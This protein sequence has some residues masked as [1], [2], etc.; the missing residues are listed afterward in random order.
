MVPGNATARLELTRIYH[1]SAAHRLASPRL[2]PAANARVY[3]PCA[4][5]HGHNYQVEVTVA[6]PPDPETGMVVD[7]ERLD[8]AV[9][10]ALL[11]RLDHRQLEE[12]EGL[13]DVVTTGECLARTFW[14]WLAPVVAPA[15][16]RR[17]AVVETAKNR[18]EYAGEQP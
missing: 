1:F 8:R 17:V 5:L 3:G 6:G 16:L 4:R 15:V 18:F 13:R 11:D 9:A 12:V 14:A 10:R 7:L 2:S